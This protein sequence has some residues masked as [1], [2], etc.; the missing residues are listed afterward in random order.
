M[1]NY[2]VNSYVDAVWVGWSDVN[3]GM[4]GHRVDMN[5]DVDDVSVLRLY[6]TTA[7]AATVEL[8]RVG[9]FVVGDELTH[10]DR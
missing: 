1:V 8:S 9:T 5:P 10:T 6:I 4:S 3:V 2:K 7:S